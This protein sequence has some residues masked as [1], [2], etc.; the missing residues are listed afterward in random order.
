[1]SEINRIRFGFV[2]KPII[3]NV[4][5]IIDVNKNREALVQSFKP[6]RN[7]DYS[8]RYNTSTENIEY[9]QKQVAEY[10]GITPEELIGKSRRNEFIIPRHTSIVLCETL[11]P[12]SMKF[13]AKNHGGRDH[14]TGINSKKIVNDM[15]FTNPVYRGQFAEL[16]NNLEKFLI[17]NK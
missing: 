15:K 11:L 9:V 3:P 8:K 4:P 12:Q 5:A 17:I 1:M 14:A 2:D 16:K 6:V 7:P 10:Y 13:I